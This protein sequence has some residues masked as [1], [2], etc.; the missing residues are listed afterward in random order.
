MEPG[1]PAEKDRLAA[2]SLVTAGGPESMVV[3]GG[4][5]STVHVERAGVRST[6]PAG[7]VARTPKLCVPSARPSYSAGELQVA[8]GAASSEH[9]KL[10]PGSSAEKAKAAE[11]LRVSASGPESMLVCG[12]L[13]SIV[14]E[15]VAGV[16]SVLPAGS[17][18]RT[19]NVCSPSSRPA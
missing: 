14:Q 2:V 3:S 6:L 9:S 1:S 11:A 7:S 10:A 19:A 18:A 17:V 8:N 13:V 4:I 5:V 16:E 15:Y 12:G